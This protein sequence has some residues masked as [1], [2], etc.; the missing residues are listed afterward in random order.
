MG[1]WSFSGKLMHHGGKKKSETNTK[2]FLGKTNDPKSSH[3]EG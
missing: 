1:Q 2:D 3:Y